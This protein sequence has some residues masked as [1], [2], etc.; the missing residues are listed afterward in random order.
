L[1]PVDDPI[2]GITQKVEKV[3]HF[4]IVKVEGNRAQIDCHRPRRPPHRNRYPESVARP[5][6][7]IAVLW[8]RVPGHP[9]LLE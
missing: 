5:L 1:A 8:R 9:M 4:V 2:P 3:E 7:E 6:L